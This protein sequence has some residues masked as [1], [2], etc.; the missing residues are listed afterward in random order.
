MHSNVD[1]NKQDQS[2]CHN[3]SSD[4]TTKE[5]T[6]LHD[7]PK[8]V[9]PNLQSA[10]KISITDDHHQLSNTTSSLV[11]EAHSSENRRMAISTQNNDRNTTIE[12]GSENVMRRNIDS[13]HQSI[14]DMRE[15]FLER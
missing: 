10:Q 15:E 5:D 13:L 4:S 14:S 2:E 7:E 6:P 3:K 11:E 12:T 8:K 1:I 9:L